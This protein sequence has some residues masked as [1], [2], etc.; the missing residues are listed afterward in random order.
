MKFKLTKFITLL[1]FLVT[2]LFQASIARAATFSDNFEDGIYTD[3]WN[4]LQESNPPSPINAVILSETDG[5]L[6]LE[7]EHG[8]GAAFTQS[9]TAFPSDNL[10]ISFWMSNAWLKERHGW[11]TDGNFQTFLDLVDQDGNFIRISNIAL[12]WFGINTLARLEIYQKDTNQWSEIYR[13]PQGLI[14]GTDNPANYRLVMDG[15]TIKLY[16]NNLE[17]PAYS[18]SN[19]TNPLRG[20]VQIRFGVG[21]DGYGWPYWCSDCASKLR[22]KLDNL[23]IISNNRFSSFSAKV[24]AEIGSEIAENKLEAKGNFILG[25]ASDGINPVNENVALSFFDVF[26]EIPA[27]SFKWFEHPKK[28]EKSEWQ[29]EGMIN[30]LPIEMKIKPLGNNSYEFKFEAESLNLCWLKSSVE[31]E[32]KIGDDF[33]KV[34]VVPEIKGLENWENICAD[35]PSPESTP[36]VSPD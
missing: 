11:R 34:E 6:K 5:V 19:F 13:F 14:Q 1:L 10:D 31:V 21:G 3:K 15:K 36:G 17:T 23:M 20:N 22:G 4:S 28:P 18:Q 27:G 33:G 8:Y 2:L 32:L 7:G 25:E 26:F 12:T 16:V 24:E 9:Q 29:F 35:A 30:N